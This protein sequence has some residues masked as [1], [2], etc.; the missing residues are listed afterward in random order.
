MEIAIKS[1]I[2]AQKMYKE[3]LELDTPK[4][5]E[6][7]IKNFVKNERNHEKILRNI[8]DD[9]YPEKDPKPVKKSVSIEGQIKSEDND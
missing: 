4:E 2:E 7:R 9:W 5:F 6:D 8:F 3:F 1:E